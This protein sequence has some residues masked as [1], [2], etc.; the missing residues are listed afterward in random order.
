MPIYTLARNTSISA[1]LCFLLAAGLSPGAVAQASENGRLTGTVVDMNDEIVPFA[2]VVLRLPESDELVTGTTSGES[3]NFDLAAAAGSYTLVISYVAYEQ[4]RLDIQLE[5]GQTLALGRIELQPDEAELDEVVV[6]RERSYMEMSFNSRRFNVG[7]DITS[8]GGDALDVL[9]NVPSITTDFEGNVSLRGNQSVQILINGK[10]SS[11][12]RDGTDGLSRIPANVIDEIEIITNPSARYSAEGTGGIIDVKLKDGVEL[13]FNGSIR[14]NTG[15]PQ[16]HGLGVDLNYQNSNINWFLGINGEFEREPEDGQTFQSFSGDTTY[17]FREMSDVTETE[18][19]GE[20]FLGADIFLP[21]DQVLTASFQAQRERGR[22]DRALSYADFQPGQPGIYRNILDE[23][24][25]NQ[26][27]T[28]RNL[29]DAYE[30]D[31]EARLQY[32]NRFD[33]SG[34]HRLLA[35]ASFEFGNDEENIGISQLQAT[36]TA[37]FDP[38]RTYLDES[39]REFRVDVDYERA[40]GEQAQLEAG[41]RI[42]TDWEDSNYRDEIFLNNSWQLR[43]NGGVEAQN[44]TYLENVNALYATYSGSVGDFTYQAGVRAE[45]T[46]IRTELKQTGEENDQNYLNLFPSS[47]LSYTISEQNSLQL[48]YSRRI[49]RPWSGLLLPFEEQRDSRN[50]R[51]G[52]PALKPEYGNSFEFG[53]LRRWES[54]S[55]LTSLYYRYRTDVIERVFTVDGNGF[56]TRRPINLATENAYGVEFSADQDVFNNFQLSASMNIF[57]SERD[58]AFEGRQYTSETESFISRMRLRWQFLPG[59]NFQTNVFYRGPQ[60]TTQ[61]TRGASTYL[62]AG[63]SKRI[64]DGQGRLSLS[65]RDITNSRNSDR[66]VL[67]S[68]S[69]TNTRYSW[70]SRSIRLSFNYNFST[71]G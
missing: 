39:Y 8:L 47:F 32:E 65:A 21:A 54:G 58:G 59:W 45:N 18:G 49:S 64:L 20:L 62:G 66:E 26:Q 34:D 42:D 22:E 46:R 60:N 28:R 29:E 48:S 53:Y 7:R 40:L 36:N 33:K 67:Q 12:V 51:V 10:P 70:S 9:D 14:A 25:V 61:G 24:Q 3:G 41:M 52:N 43:D 71:A 63:L 50:I 15:F 44:F 13:G 35:D 11:I 30:W 1:L 5:A 38:R 2:N 68:D 37:G 19:E 69:Y 6:Q 27:Y 56:T 57:Q 17:V 4:R 55:V 16:D 23:W 31:Y